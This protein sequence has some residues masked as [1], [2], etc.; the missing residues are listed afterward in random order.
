[1]IARIGPKTAII[2]IAAITL[3]AAAVLYAIGHPLMCKC[4]YVKLWHGVTYSSENSQHLSDW[5][6]PSHV[7]HG[8]L[9]YALLWL[10]AR[11]WSVSTRAIIA[12]LI[13]A[14]WEILENT[15]L[16]I[17]RYR[18]TT[19]SLDYFG[20]SVINSVMDI[21]W[22]LLGFVLAARL[23]VWVSV[24]LVVALELFVGYFIRD[25]LTLN[26]IMLLYPVDA[27]RIWQGGG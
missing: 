12:T 6:T 25:N 16:I 11:K 13:E 8:L 10:V 22:M 14:G 20:D 7:I 15:P 26:I 24:A 2:A 3:A 5:Y 18:E 4:G 21:A 1:V 27:I 17:N 19:I 23:P 9:F